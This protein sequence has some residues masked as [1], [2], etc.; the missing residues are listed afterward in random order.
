[1]VCSNYYERLHSLFYTAGIPMQQGQV[2]MRP[3]NELDV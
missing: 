3:V 2:V 1:M